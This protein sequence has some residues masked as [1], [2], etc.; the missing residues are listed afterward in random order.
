[1]SDHPIDDILR[2][3]IQ[4][5]ID[6]HQLYASAAEM[7]DQPHAAALL[8]ELAAQETGHRHRLEA[9]LAGNVFQA[10][11]QAQQRKVIDLK[12]SDYLVEVPLAPDSDLQDVLIVAAKRENASHELYASLAQV[13]EEAE[14][15]RLFEYLA[16]EELAH[17]NRVET[18][19]E[20]IIY[21]DN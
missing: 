1:M 2:T 5:E 13:A 8:R 11:S 4:R 6:A 18:L 12:I 16:G 10:L 21:R 14:T 19:Y 15:V 17:K 7:A 9:L 3:A 20:E